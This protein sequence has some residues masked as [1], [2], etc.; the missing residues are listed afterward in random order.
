MLNKSQNAYANSHSGVPMFINLFRN[1]ISLPNNNHSP[2]V[3]NTT[4]KPRPIHMYM[5]TLELNENVPIIF[6][7]II[8]SSNKNNK[9]LMDEWIKSM[10]F[11]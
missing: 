5:A 9:V 11:N 7:P 3:I 6:S 4:N 8:E 1:M 2:H 10:L